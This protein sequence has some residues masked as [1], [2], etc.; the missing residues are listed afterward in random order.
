MCEYVSKKKNSG[1][2]APFSAQKTKTSQ[3]VLLKNLYH[4]VFVIALG[5]ILENYFKKK[6]KK[7]GEN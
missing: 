4:H 2:I 1:K 5:D 7:G 6:E 3:A